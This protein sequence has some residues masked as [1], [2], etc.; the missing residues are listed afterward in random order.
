MRRILQVIEHTIMKSNSPDAS[1]EQ[2]PQ[3]L[4]PSFNSNANLVS[5]LHW[6]IMTRWVNATLAATCEITLSQYID[7]HNSESQVSFRPDE[8]VGPA[9]V[10][11]DSSLLQK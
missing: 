7:Y 9:F 3:V 2:L 11:R 5:S 8:N 6:P 1:E 4:F 10:K